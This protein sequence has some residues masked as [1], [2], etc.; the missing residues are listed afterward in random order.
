MKTLIVSVTFSKRGT[1]PNIA[2]RFL[3]MFLVD[4]LISSTAKDV[5]Y[6]T[7]VLAGDL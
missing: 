1:S 3:A 7:T 2:W 4:N 6:D 5:R